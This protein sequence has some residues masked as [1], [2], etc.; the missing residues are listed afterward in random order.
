[1][2]LLVVPPGRGELCVFMFTNMLFPNDDGRCVFPRVSN[3]GSF[4]ITT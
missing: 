3:A 1:L 2:L 4:T